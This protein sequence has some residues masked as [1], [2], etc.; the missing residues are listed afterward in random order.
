MDAGAGT[1]PIVSELE[2]FTVIAGESITL[3][4]MGS[5][6]T[7]DAQAYVNGVAIPTT[8]VSASLVEVE[9][10]ASATIAGSLAVIVEN[11]AG[12]ASTQSNVLYLQVAALPG[13]PVIYDYSPDN[14]V[15]GDT[16]LIIASNLAG[17]TLRIADA[18]GNALEAGMLS[19]ISWPTAGTVDTVEVVLPDDIATGPITVENDIGAYRGKIF[20]VG[21]N[22]TRA[23]GTVVEASSEYNTT[24]WSKAS[25]ADNLLAT[26][27]F[28]AVGDCATLTS[29]TMTPFYV[30]TLA[31]DQDIQRI[32]MRGNREYAS[33]YDF[34]RGR[35]M[36]LDE[37]GD[38]VWQ[39]EYDLPA[40]D[41]DL[42]ITL[43]EPV[44]AR[45]FRFESLEDE[46]SEPGFAEIELF[47]Q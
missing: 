1:Q 22:L 4:I 30:I 16:I 39:G 23:A 8:F 10:P 40:P 36:L 5:G 37:G 27:F 11:V 15:P 7:E 6:F 17:Q 31:S 34:I 19:T 20:S 47:G 29:C 3:Q 41:R 28:T 9:V 26:S 42:D 24:N 44:R 46:S 35:F 38:P 12:D 43:P 45:A 13:A 32:A 25:G 21:M 18:E 14:G 33:G 2:P